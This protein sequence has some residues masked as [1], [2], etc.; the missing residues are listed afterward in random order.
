M[1]V[2]EYHCDKC[3]REVTLTLTISEYEKGPLKCPKCGGRVQV[4]DLLEELPPPRSP[5]P[6][7]TRA[8]APA[9]RPRDDD[10]DDEYDRPRRQSQYDE[11]ADDRPARR[12]FLLMV[13]GPLTL[14]VTSILDRDVLNE[15]HETE[16][17]AHL[18][19]LSDEDATRDFSEFGRGQV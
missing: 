12:S 11:Y 2:Y 16:W 15:E 8:G 7:T 17:R 4:P 10:Y 3:Q 13:P 9:R 6:E 14:P 5:R 1:P 18:G 19:G